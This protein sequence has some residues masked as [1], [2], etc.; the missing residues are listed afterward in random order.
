MACTFIGL[1]SNVGDRQHYLAAALIGLKT[2]PHTTV[3]AVSTVREYAPVGGPPQGA[4]LNAVA[5][6]ETT[7]SPEQLLAHLHLLEMALGRDRAGTVRWG[8]RPIDLDLL[9]YDQQIMTDPRCTVPHPR[10]QERLFVLEPLAELAPNV[11]HPSLGV[12]I[13]VLLEQLR[14]HAAP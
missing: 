10:L 13:A 14:A 7:L 5:D 4:Y 8:P 1:G 9:L 6:V 2:L 3:R 12:T 11:V